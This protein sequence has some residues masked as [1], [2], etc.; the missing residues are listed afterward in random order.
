MAS[1]DYEFLTRWRVAAPPGEVFRVI[2]DVPGYPQWW[3]EV[4]LAVTAVEPGDADKVGA[5][6]ALHTRGRLPYTLRWES[7]TTEKTF[8]TRIALDATGDFVGRGVWTFAPAAG[9]GTDVTYDWRLR[10][11]KPLLRR[12][13]FVL[14]PLFRWN[15]DWAMARGYEGLVRELARRAS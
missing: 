13:S 5:R 10:A 6:Y 7:R 15:H 1:N 14:K 8:P 2:D 3:P 9:G 4:W 11:E 12:L